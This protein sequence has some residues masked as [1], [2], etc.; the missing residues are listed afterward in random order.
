MHKFVAVSWPRMAISAYHRNGLLV[1][2]YIM[3]LQWCSLLNARG[4]HSTSNVV[5]GSECL[6]NEPMHFMTWETAGLSNSKLYN[7]YHPACQGSQLESIIVIVK[8]ARMHTQYSHYYAHMHTHTHN[9]Y[10][11]AS[12]PLTHTK[13][14]PIQKHSGSSWGLCTLNFSTAF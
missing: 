4:L 3:C 11:I 14:S 2:S 10:N 12:Y 6:S 1:S 9:N 13:S 8:H 5:N 7:P